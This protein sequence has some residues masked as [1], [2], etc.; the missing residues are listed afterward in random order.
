MQSTEIKSPFPAK[1]LRWLALLGGTVVVHSLVYALLLCGGTFENEW[2]FWVCATAILGLPTGWSLFILWRFR[3]VA[4]RLVG[5]LS[6]IS[7]LFELSFLIGSICNT[8]YEVVG[9]QMNQ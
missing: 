5:F 9:D 1:R 2:V 7:S 4:E 6:F 3:S 8:L